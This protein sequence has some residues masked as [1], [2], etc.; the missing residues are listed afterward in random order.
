MAALHGTVA[1]VQVQDVA[2]PVAQDLHFDVLGA[3]DVALEEDR[4]VAERRPGLLARLVD[5][6]VEVLGPVHHA[7]AAAAAA[8][9]GL[10]DQRE[11]DLVPPSR[12][13]P[14]G[15][16]TGSS[17]PGMVGMPAFSARRRAAVLSPSSSSRSPLGPT[18]AMPCLAQARGSAGFSDRKP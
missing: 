13:P 17:V 5:A 1:L 6:G 4:A 11:T 7:H 14:A 12:A 8:E 3:A 9:R 15:S 16:L 2:V 18:K 10:D